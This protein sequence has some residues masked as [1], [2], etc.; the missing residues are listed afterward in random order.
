MA[1]PRASPARLQH[2]CVQLLLYPKI[3][4]TTPL[5]VSYTNTIFNISMSNLIYVIHFVV[6]K[7]MQFSMQSLVSSI[8][9]AEK[10]LSMIT[11]S[12]P[13]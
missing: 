2:N 8:K 3:R 9:L 13:D 7:L 5:S 10:S 4:Y 12:M 11:S 1:S 6:N